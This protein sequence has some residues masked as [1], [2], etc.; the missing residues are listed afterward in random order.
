[1]KQENCET[2]RHTPG[3]RSRSPHLLLSHFA[4]YTENSILFRCYSNILEQLRTYLKKH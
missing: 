2:F 4:A 3:I 1:M